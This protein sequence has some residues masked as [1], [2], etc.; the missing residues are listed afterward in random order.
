MQLYKCPGAG[1]S[2]RG[3]DRLLR[4]ELFTTHRSLSCVHIAASRVEAKPSYP[5]KKSGYQQ[6]V[7][8]RTWRLELSVRDAL[9][10][11]HRR[12]LGGDVGVGGAAVLGDVAA[13]NLELLRDAEDAGRL[14][15]EEHDDRAG[16]DPR[17]DD[18]GRHD[19]RGKQRAAAA[20]KEA[21]VGTEVHAHVVQAPR[22]ARGRSVRVG[23]GGQEANGNA[24]PEAA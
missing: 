6:H 12:D 14:E 2:T 15:A 11:F 21:A 5:A 8:L 19:L 10:L 16:A 1:S 22:G 4:D 13:G 7:A 24:A 3:R 20:V 9:G 17:D 23:R 18:D